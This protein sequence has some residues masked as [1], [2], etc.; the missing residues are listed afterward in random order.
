MLLFKLLCLIVSMFVFLR[1]S[2]QHVSS[3]FSVLFDSCVT[4]WLDLLIASFFLCLIVKIS[5][6]F[7]H[8]VIHL[9]D[10]LFLII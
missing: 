5:T 9:F 7:I 3:V 2:L 10:C 6:L 4:V 1:Q 8:L